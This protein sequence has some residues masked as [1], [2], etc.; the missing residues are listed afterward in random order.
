[1]I[2]KLLR[3]RTLSAYVCVAAKTAIPHGE[4]II[5]STIEKLNKK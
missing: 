5:N 3:L 2:K 1:M 4:I